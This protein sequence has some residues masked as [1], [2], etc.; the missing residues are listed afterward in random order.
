[1]KAPLPQIDKE[2]EII[3]IKPILENWDALL[4]VEG[5]KA[6]GIVT[7]YDILKNV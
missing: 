3:K 6:I 7:I 2:T 5:G 1:M 4:V